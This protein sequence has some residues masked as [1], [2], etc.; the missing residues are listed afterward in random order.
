MPSGQLGSNTAPRPEQLVEN[1]AL[2][3]RRQ[4]PIDPPLDFGG[5]ANLMGVCYF[6]FCENEKPGKNL[7]LS[8]FQACEA[9]VHERK[10]RTGMRFV[11]LGWNAAGFVRGRCAGLSPNVRL[12][13]IAV[14]HC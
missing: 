4:I 13:G 10:Y 3:T 14:E 5:F 1:L 2:Q 11:R 8:F 9:R 12:A 7:F 6:D